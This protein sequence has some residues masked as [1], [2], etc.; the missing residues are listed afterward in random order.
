M[1]VFHLVTSFILAVAI[2]FEDY[3][4]VLLQAILLPKSFNRE[5][6]NRE[7]IKTCYIFQK[8]FYRNYI[9]KPVAILL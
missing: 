2:N 8:L 1:V 3:I 4:F 6:T 9:W 5:L 7:Q